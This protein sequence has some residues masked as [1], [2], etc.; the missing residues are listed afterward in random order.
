MSSDAPNTEI[1]SIKASDS[2]AASNGVTVVPLAPTNEERQQIDAIVRISKSSVLL[3]PDNST[4][5][6]DS[7]LSSY[8]QYHPALDSIIFTALTI[9]N[10][11]WTA[12]SMFGL[13][14]V[15]RN[16]WGKGPVGCVVFANGDSACFQVNPMAPGASRVL[17][18]SA[19]NIDG[20]AISISG[21]SPIL[22]GGDTSVSVANESPSSGYVSYSMGGGFEKP[23][24][25]CV[26]VNDTVERCTVQPK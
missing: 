7:Y 24:V 18:N 22:N 6:F 1:S 16:F 15:L 10:P 2:T 14:A 13:W 9:N 5:Y 25:T 23:I 17:A 8:N 12:Q 4:G 3:V 20:E 11:A 21:D 19:K 26:R